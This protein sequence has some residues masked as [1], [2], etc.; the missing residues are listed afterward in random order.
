MKQNLTK[1]VRIRL[2][3]EIISK[4]HAKNLSAFI[5]DAVLEK[6]EKNEETKIEIPF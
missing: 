6:L 3:D 4:I 2:S 1:I 5:R